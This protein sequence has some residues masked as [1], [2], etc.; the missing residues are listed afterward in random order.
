[1]S[2]ST[3]ITTPDG[4]GIRLSWPAG[5]SSYFREERFDGFESVGENVKVTPVLLD[6]GEVRLYAEYALS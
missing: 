1:M 2:E 4:R 6:T 5:A 3:K